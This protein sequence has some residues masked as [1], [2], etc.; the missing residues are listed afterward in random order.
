MCNAVMNMHEDFNLLKPVN[1][2]GSALL[3]IHIWSNPLLEDVICW[4]DWEMGTAI[5][6]TKCSEVAGISTQHI[7]CISNSMIDYE[8][9]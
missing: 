4:G 1:I 9:K 3:I 6:C 2:K 5:S 8:E 7:C